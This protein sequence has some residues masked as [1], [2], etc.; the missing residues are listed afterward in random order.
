MLIMTIRF[1]VIRARYIKFHSVVKI[2]IKSSHELATVRPKR[3]L[4]LCSTF[5]STFSHL[6]FQLFSPNTQ[7]V[8]PLAL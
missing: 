2:Q 7:T 6:H 5:Q 3:V 8:I 1:D 4:K